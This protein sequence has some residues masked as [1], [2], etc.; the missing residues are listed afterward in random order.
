LFWDKITAWFDNFG[1]RL[2]KTTIG[3]TNKLIKAGSKLEDKLLGVEDDAREHVVKAAVGTANIL[4]DK[5]HMDKI[6]SA[7]SGIVDMAVSAAS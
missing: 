5:D 3:A 7:G 1:K 6:I 4:G 2:K